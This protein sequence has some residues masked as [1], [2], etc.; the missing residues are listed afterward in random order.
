MPNFVYTTL[1]ASGQDEIKGKITAPTEA[2][3]LTTLKGQGFFVLKI[4]VE[5]AE[6]RQ[7]GEL[8]LDGLR[9]SIDPP[10]R[11]YT[12]IL[13][14]QLSVLL[15]SGVS[16]MRA[17][18][19]L[20][21]QSTSFGMRRMMRTIRL[22]VEAGNTLSQSLEE[23]P[24]VFSSYVTNMIAAAE[25]S[26]EMETAMN[27]IADQLE[28]S[29]E[30][31]RQLI[32]SLIYPGFVLVAAV[33]VITFLTLSV[34]PKFQAL[35]GEGKALPWVT[36]TIMDISGWMQANW[37]YLFGG[38][39]AFILSLVLL[40]K[41]NQGKFVV[42]TCMLHVPVIAPVVQCSIVVNYARNLAMLFASGV[43]LVEALGTIRKTLGNEAAVRVL[44]AMIERIMEGENM[45]T[46]LAEHKKV[47]PPMVYEMV[48]TGEETGEM[49]K[50]LEL[51][52]NIYQ[53]MLQTSVKRMNAMMEPLII[54][55]LGGIVGFVIYGLISGML[56]VYGL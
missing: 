51:T 4:E 5:R 53:S 55:V 23:Y 14:R 35:L 9:T 48:R 47:F 16:I 34:I 12:P 37:M 15:D 18:L 46:T 20:E 25:L 44:N 13:F 10:K 45:S 32:T 43:P 38:I 6:T 40:R 56:A 11:K 1:S 41:T 39:A 42:D 3:A 7:K 33:G 36:Q 28:S 27:R 31:K 19:L 29:A 52:A 8:S 17:L 22:N 49:V 30:F 54:V 2:E 26:G 21:N 24:S 50:V